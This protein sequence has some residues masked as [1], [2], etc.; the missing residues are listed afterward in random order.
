MRNTNPIAQ[1]PKQT[2]PQLNV[3][4][5]GACNKIA[6][7]WPLSN[8]VAVN[9]FVGLAHQSFATTAAQCQRILDAA[10]VMPLAWYQQHYNASAIGMEDIRA[11]VA[12]APDEVKEAFTAAAVPLTADHLIELLDHPQVI[13]PPALQPGPFSGFM[14]QRENTTWQHFIREETAK[15]CAAY[16]DRGQSTWTLP[17]ASKTL[18]QAWQC[19]AAMDRNPQCNG[20]KHFCRIVAELP[21]EPIDA[22]QSALTALN[23]PADYTEE[24]LYRI[25][26]MVSGWAGHMRYLDR[27]QTL[28]GASSDWLVQ[29][30]AIILNYEVILFHH[31]KDNHDRILGWKRTLM[32]NPMDTGEPLVAFELAQRIIWQSSFEHALEQTLKSKIRPTPPDKA[33]APEIRPSVQAAFCIDVRSEVLRRA[34]ESTHADIQTL[35]FAGFFGLP[36]DHT[37]PGQETQ[38]ARCPVL[39]QPHINTCEHH[40]G[41]AEADAQAIQQSATQQR[42]ARSGWK[43][44]RE[45]ATSSF[46]FVETLGLSYAYKFFKDTLGWKTEATSAWPG[47]PAIIDDF[48]LEQQ[49]ELAASI[50]RGLNLTRNFAPLVLLCGHGSA[51]KNN[52]Y[53]SGLDCGACGGHAG[54]ANARIAVALFNNPEVR[55]ALR[56]RHIKIPND[57]HF[58]A[59]LHNTTTDDI[60]LFDRDQAPAEIMPQVLALQIHLQQASTQAALERS[61]QLSSDGK[62][63]QTIA[64]VRQRSCDW[65]QVRPEW[66]LAGNHAFIVAPRAWTQHANLKGRVFLHDYDAAYDPNSDLLRAILGGPLIVGSWINLQYYGSAVDNAHFGS[67]HKSIHNVVGGIGVALGNENDLRPGLPFQSVHNGKH[68]VHEP[69]RLLACIAAEPEVIDSIIKS[70]AELSQLVDNQWLR[71]VALGSDGKNWQPC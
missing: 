53:G 59:G 16:V 70:H 69:A 10:L 58:I 64:A 50:L 17:W 71:I 61:Q 43:Q 60:T 30:L 45:A 2:R 67:G 35:G 27:Q 7:L 54:D 52:P 46:S 6:P 37:H 13:E 66:G 12:A 62:P 32:E 40:G 29:L 68:L 4:I 14:D 34:L 49:A 22:I 11:A 20:L 39:L 28:Q 65:S 44:F 47:A 51:T 31:F 8:F 38:Q 23:I 48:D 55:S 15:W 1:Q 36:I 42:R 3:S 25:L 18:Y 63:L 57:T 9:P 19:A 21:N 41:L 33:I 24:F 5:A 56:A 26:L